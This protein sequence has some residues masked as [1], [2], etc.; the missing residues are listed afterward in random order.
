M[1]AYNGG[2]RNPNLQCAAGVQMVAEYARNILERVTAKSE[3]ATEEGLER[4][5]STDSNTSASEDFEMG[6]VS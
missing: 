5:M 4:G 3:E 6:G 2:P 1:G